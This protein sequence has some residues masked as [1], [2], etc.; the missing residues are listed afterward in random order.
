MMIRRRF[1]RPNYARSESQRRILRRQIARSGRG[2]Q[3][4]K[5]LQ[6]FLR[7]GQSNNNSSEVWSTIGLFG[8][9]ALLLIGL[10][11]IIRFGKLALPPHG[12]RRRH[13]KSETGAD[14][15]SVPNYGSQENITDILSWG[16]DENWPRKLWCQF[17]RCGW[18]LKEEKKRSMFCHLIV[19]W[20]HWWQLVRRSRPWEK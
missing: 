18:S 9:V 6:R 5:R 14:S 3:T 15:V 4:L 7:G 16:T 1:M 17:N 20:S 12:H 2:G 8:F 11:Y 13:V 19:I 10:K